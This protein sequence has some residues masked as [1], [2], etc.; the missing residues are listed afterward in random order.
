MYTVRCEELLFIELDFTCEGFYPRLS[1][2]ES[3]FRLGLYWHVYFEENVPEIRRDSDSLHIAIGVT[4]EGP[5]P[6]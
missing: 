6:L 1:S 5:V 4:V 3:C 2:W